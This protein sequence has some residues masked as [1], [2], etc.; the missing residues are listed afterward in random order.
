MFERCQRVTYQNT[1]VEG[2]AA[3]YSRPELPQDPC[4]I[5]MAVALTYGTGGAPEIAYVN[6]SSS[7]ATLQFLGLHNYNGVAHLLLKYQPLDLLT[8]RHGA[9]VCACW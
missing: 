8:V 4:A 9:L 1:S 6:A 5:D 7:V 2:E 3:S